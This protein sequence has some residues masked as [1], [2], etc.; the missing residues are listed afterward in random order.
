[1]ETSNSNKSGGN[2][3][4][5]SMIPIWPTSLIF[6]ACVT[7]ASTF[8]VKTAT[9]DRRISKNSHIRPAFIYSLGAIGM[10]VSVS[11]YEKILVPFLRKVTGN[12]RGIN[13]LQRIGIGMIFSTLSMAAA[14]CV[15]MKRL[16]AVLR[17]RLFKKGKKGSL[18]MSLF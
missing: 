14:V 10:M 11:T 13:I 6:E 5:L 12:E 7:Q 1:M 15:E 18:S 4:F 3:A 17:R 16:K 8:F 9:V 2:E